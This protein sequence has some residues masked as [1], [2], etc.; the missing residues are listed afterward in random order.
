MN[1]E[2]QKQTYLDDS[3]EYVAVEVAISAM[4]AEVLHRFGASVTHQ[5]RHIMNRRNIC[6]QEKKM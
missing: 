3:V 5:K 1:T 2:G 4:N 6:I